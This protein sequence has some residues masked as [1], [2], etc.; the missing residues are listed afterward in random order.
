M[1]GSA[2]NGFESLQQNSQQAA[3]VS[4]DIKLPKINL[5]LALGA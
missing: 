5:N 2:L 1:Q 4:R 3:M